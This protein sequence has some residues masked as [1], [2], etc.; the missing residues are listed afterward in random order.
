[1]DWRDRARHELRRAA[2]RYRDRAERKV[3]R[4]GVMRAEAGE[5]AEA[6]T[7]DVNLGE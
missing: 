1:M 6:D 7:G 2:Q 4:H 3:G 5:I